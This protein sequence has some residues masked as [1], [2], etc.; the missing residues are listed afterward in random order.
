VREEIAASAVALVRSIVRL[1][2]LIGYL[3]TT[4]AA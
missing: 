2:E 1:A 3:L 4:I